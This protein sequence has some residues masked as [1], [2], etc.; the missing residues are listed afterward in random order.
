MKTG[1]RWTTRKAV[2]EAES[3]LQ[4]KKIV[5]NV[6]VG[7]RG[8]GFGTSNQPGVHNQTSYR[9]QILNEV[10]NSEEENRISK[11]V[12]MGPQ[13]AWTKWEQVP[14]R[15][16]KWNELWKMSP[17][18]ARFLIRSVYDVL[19]TP[20]NL[21]IW[22]KQEDPKCS[23]CQ[24]MCTL[25]HILSSCP[26]SLAQGRYTWRHNHVLESIV[27]ILQDE[28]EK[29]TKTQRKKVT[30]IAF[31]KAGQGDKSVKKSSTVCGIINTAGD[32]K[33]K[34][35]L[36]KQMIFPTHIAITTKRPDIVLYSDESKQVVLLELTVPWETRL[37]E[38][39]ERKKLSYEELRKDCCDN[40]WTCWCFPIEVGCRG[41]P[42]QSLLNTA[43]RLGI[44][45]KNR[46]K[47]LRDVSER[48]EVA[49]H[50]IW[51][52]HLH[53]GKNLSLGKG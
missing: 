50:W 27:A 51:M 5:G 18:R 52:K 12:Q 1:R 29:A 6:S 7:R 31:C 34:T 16:V 2:T 19:P 10:R 17:T 44:Q 20:T 39:Y 30:F 28:I 36:V 46:K 33:L 53:S 38:A 3:R 24:R 43:K 21:C 25:E 40:G 26:I 45:A 48:A 23:Q 4:H 47:L 8:L 37:E 41:F 14:K 49:S 35:D 22:G 13:G 15:D 42:S 32:W 9:D 11:A